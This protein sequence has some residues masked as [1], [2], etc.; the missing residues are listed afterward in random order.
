MPASFLQVITIAADL[1]IFVFVGFYLF[2]LQRDKAKLE[3]QKQDLVARQANIETEYK[4][5]IEN[6]LLKEK[7]ILEDAAQSAGAIIQNTQFVADSARQLIEK[8]L[9]NMLSQVEKEAAS[10]SGQSSQ[11]YKDYLSKLSQ[12]SLDNFQNLTK[13]FEEEM[14]A[15]M[16]DYRQTLL[17]QMQKE[18]EE[19]K[20]KKLKEADAKIE[21]VIQKVAQSVLNKSLALDDHKTLIIES[22]EKSRKEGVFD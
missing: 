18:T 1:M 17:A 11:V 20:G 13:K 2:I 15:Q 7:K 6:A 12:Q 4:K 16:Q 14:Q 22:L 19:Y 10:A 9:Q 21:L 8:A 3:K 5:T